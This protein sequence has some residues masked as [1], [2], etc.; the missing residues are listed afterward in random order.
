MNTQKELD[1]GISHSVIGHKPIKDSGK[2]QQF[3]TGAVRDAQSGKGRYDLLPMRAIARLARHFEAGAKKYGDRN[4]EKGIPISRYM[5]SG[6]RHLCKYM[7]GERDEDH[8]AA[9]A[10]NIMCAMD[11][12]ERILKDN[13]LEKKL[14]DIPNNENNTDK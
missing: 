8:L 12:E 11:T 2:R 10:W 4:W 5:D 6:M 9:C 3:N 7:Q 1:G 14:Y 13:I